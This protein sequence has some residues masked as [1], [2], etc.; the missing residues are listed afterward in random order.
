M[1]G[2]FR[3]SAGRLI[4]IYVSLLHPSCR[5]LQYCLKKSFGL[6]LELPGPDRIT[7]LH[8]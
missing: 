4:A 2:A 7:T 6:I 5:G 3:K 1:I 8:Q